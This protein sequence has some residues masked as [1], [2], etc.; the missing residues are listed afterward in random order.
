[1]LQTAASHNSYH[2]GQIV[3]L[4]QMLGAWPASRKRR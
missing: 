4:R 1:M 2:A 3:I